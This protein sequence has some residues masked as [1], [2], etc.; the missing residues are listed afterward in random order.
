MTKKTTKLNVVIKNSASSE[1]QQVS[2]SEEK[3]AFTSQ[4][5]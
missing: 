3:N 2:F 4:K 5:L 1:E